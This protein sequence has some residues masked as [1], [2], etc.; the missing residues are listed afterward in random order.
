V[1]VL[2]SD[3]LLPLEQFD[4]IKVKD[5][6]E[7]SRLAINALPDYQKWRNMKE[8]FHYITEW[9]NNSDADDNNN[10]NNKKITLQ[11]CGVIGGG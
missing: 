7:C 3:K 11:H 9:Q 6:G 8:M 2:L 5:N 1:V 10:N 4:V